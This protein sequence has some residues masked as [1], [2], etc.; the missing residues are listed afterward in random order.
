MKNRT[1]R[2]I[3]AAAAIAMCLTAG[4]GNV[5]E[6]AP[7]PANAP[8]T[9]AETVTVDTDA[10]EEAAGT[11]GEITAET[12]TKE[13][14]TAPAKNTRF[15]EDGSFLTDENSMILDDDVT[16][17]KDTVRRMAAAVLRQYDTIA[18]G[19]KKAYYDSVGISALLKNEK[20][21]DLVKEDSVS[22]PEDILLHAALLLGGVVSLEDA[23]LFGEKPEGMTDEEFAA[24]NITKIRKAAYTMT[25]EKAAMLFGED[26]PFSLF[27]SE[28]HEYAVPDEFK[29]DTSLRRFEPGDDT[30]YCISVSDYSENERGVSAEFGISVLHGDWAYIFDDCIVWEHGSGEYCTLATDISIEVNEY[31]GKKPD[32]IMNETVQLSRLKTLNANAK[33]AYN[34]AAEFFADKEFEGHSLDE[35]FASGAFRLAASKEGLSLAEKGSDLAE[36]DARFI[37]VFSECGFTEGTVYLGRTD[38][39]GEDTFFIQYKTDESGMIGQY[40]DCIEPGRTAEAVWGEYLPYVYDEQIAEQTESEE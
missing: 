15:P 8:E 3:S 5:D 12:E 22:T 32:E 11:S 6:A 31:K 40:P 23:E 39:L 16:Y 4:C 9:A 13:L 21:N 25:P 24:S 7:A 18:D 1:L 36:G 2:M 34:I 33:T 17:D 10:E 14:L 19:D 37:E 38:R 20:M 26:M 28:E 29:K 30:I 35:V 27:T